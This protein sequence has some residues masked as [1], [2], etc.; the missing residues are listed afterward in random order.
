VDAGVIKES[1]ANFGISVEVLRERGFEAEY[2]QLDIKVAPE[3][4]S[5]LELARSMWDEL[6]LPPWVPPPV[7]EAVETEEAEAAE[8]VE[9]EEAEAEE[10]EAEEAEAVDA[11]AVDA[12]A[13]DAEAVDA[14]AVD[15]E[16]VEAE[17]VEAEAA[18]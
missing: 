14:E 12:E 10:A 6:D 16:A 5:R 15:A 13:V 8:V 11:E 4:V 18:E 1:L 3:G 9:A 7:E 2:A 17:A